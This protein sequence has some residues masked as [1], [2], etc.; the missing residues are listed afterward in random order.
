MDFPFDAELVGRWPEYL[1]LSRKRRRVISRLR[2]RIRLRL[3]GGLS[4]SSMR[5]ASCGARAQVADPRAH[6]R[7]AG[8]DLRS[9]ESRLQGHTR[10]SAILRVTPAGGVTSFSKGLQKD[11]I[12]WYITAGSGN[13][14]WFTD[15][16]GRVGRIDTAGVIREFPIVRH[17]RHRKAS[18]TG[19]ADHHG[20]GR[21]DL[22]FIIGQQIGHV[23]LS[24]HVKIF[25]PPSSYRQPEAWRGLGGL[26]SLAAGPEG[27]L[28][29]TRVSGEV[30]RMDARG[31]VRTITNR[32][33]N[34][35][36]IAFGSNGVA[37][38]GEGR[39]S[40]PAQVAS[41]GAGG[42]VTQ[43][44]APHL[45]SAMFPTCSA[46]V[47]TTRRKTFDAAN[48]NTA[49]RDAHLTLGRIV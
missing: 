13:V 44:P 31:R 15:S 26:D 14:L 2:K 10:L 24:G 42:R 36:G 34:A 16:V 18:S 32:L 27:D 17:L 9:S 39:E 21:R 5:P 6:G 48:V 20:A 22:W 23:T 49:G 35:L 7:K 47:P 1:A 19:I 29:F 40:G 25:T 38:I 11:A 43:Y 8:G 3:W 33:V 30:E 45:V 28:W 46:M 41:I 37:W 4:T 12:P